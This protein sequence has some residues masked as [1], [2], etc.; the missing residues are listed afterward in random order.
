[1]SDSNEKCFIIMPISNPDGYPNGHFNK[2]YEQIIKPA[3][4]NAG[5]EPFRVDANK[6]SDSI[7]EKIFDGVTNF[8]MAVC[9]LSSRNPNVLYEL[10]LRHAYNMPVVLIQDDITD[11]I[12]DVG[13]INTI[14]YKSGR[15]YEDVIEAVQKLTDAINETKKA[16]G[17]NGSMVKI[18]KTFQANF[19]DIEVSKNDSFDLEL[20]SIKND[21]KQTK[22]MLETIIYSSPK[23]N[24]ENN[25][26]KENIYAKTRVYELA[27]RL[28]ITTK[29][30]IDI[31]NSLNVTVDSHMSILTPKDVNLVTKNFKQDLETLNN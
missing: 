2:V 5:Y 18:A 11:T 28:N 21:L 20:R 17:I 24:T 29:D 22:Y 30:L 25:L 14:M 16:N 12:F 7:I 10:G 23:I 4:T 19:N 9:D 13:G 8:P 27:K 3:V 15:L 26:H 1:M 31:L 6:I